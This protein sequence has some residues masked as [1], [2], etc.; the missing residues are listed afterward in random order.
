LQSKKIQI[1]TGD[2]RVLYLVGRAKGRIE[3]APPFPATTDGQGRKKTQ[4]ISTSMDELA[5]FT[6]HPYGGGVIVVVPASEKV[7]LDCPQ[8][9]CVS[10]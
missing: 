1:I 8:H 9:F 2:L 4:L 5:C 10:F 3:R 7:L 6:D